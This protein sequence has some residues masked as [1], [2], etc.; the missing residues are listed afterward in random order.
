MYAVASDHWDKRFWT[1]A[2]LAPG[3]T[4]WTWPDGSP[5]YT[6][7]RS[8]SPSTEFLYVDHTNPSR[9]VS[10][11]DSVLLYPLC[12]ASEYHRLFVH[13]NDV[14]MGEIASQ[15]TSLTID[16]STVYSDTDRRKNQSFASLAF[17]R[18][19]HRSP[20]NSPHKW[21]VTRKMFP[22]DDSIM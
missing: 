6:D 8:A 11:D 16:Y 14:I 12:E 18:G 17:V 3:V 9:Y 21:S 13:Y 15:I 20:V 10:S 2:Q 22:F 1:S 7:L 19:I 4:F 5:V